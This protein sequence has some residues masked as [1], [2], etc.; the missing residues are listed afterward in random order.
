MILA[1]VGMQREA[2]L[3]ERHGAG[4][5][6]R[7]VAGGGRAELLEQRLKA[8]LEGAEGL[9]SIGLGGALDPALEVGDVVVASEVL[10]P[11][12]RWETNP[13]WREVLLSRLPKARAGAVYGSDE[14]VLNALD[15]A[16]LRGRGGAILVD[17]ESHVAAKLAAARGLPLAV[18]RV[19]SD[20][21]TASLPEAV[22]AGLAED[23]RMDLMGVLGALARDPGQ[24]PALIRV[25]RDADLAFKA[26]GVAAA[27][28]LAGA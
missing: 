11:R 14:M 27:R 13:A 8:A 3:V 1:A 19:V 9:I 4:L 15:K 16:K 28:A 25:G 21:A 26:L 22:R 17:M 18:V 12:R 24:L 2:R 6:V 20:K 23:G 5:G 10:R 7:A